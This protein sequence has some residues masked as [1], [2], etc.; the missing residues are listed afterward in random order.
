[1]LFYTYDLDVYRDHLRGFY[2][3]FEAEAPGPL[4]SDEADLAPAVL[5]AEKIRVKH[6][7]AYRAFAER[8]CAWDDGKAAARVVDAVFGDRVPGR[9]PATREP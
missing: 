2:F 9:A 1:M 4:I 5:D 6:D 3:D 8:F 7:A